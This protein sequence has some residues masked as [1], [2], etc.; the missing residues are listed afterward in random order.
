M[1]KNQIQLSNNH[2]QF[3]K[4][5]LLLQVTHYNA[6]VFL[7]HFDTLAELEDIHTNKAEKNHYSDHEGMSKTASGG[8]AMPGMESN[9]EKDH[10]ER[11]F[12]NH[13]VEKI[14]FMHAQKMFQDL[15]IYTPADLKKLILSKLPKA[16]H[17]STKFVIGTFNYDSPIQLIDRLHALK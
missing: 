2:H 16:L 8:Y 6:R 13:L 11:V 17:N 7:T 1:I 5:T 10:L 15:I 12:V 4:S 3:D 9:H 14:K